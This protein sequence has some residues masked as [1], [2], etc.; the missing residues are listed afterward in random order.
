MQPDGRGPITEEHGLAEREPAERVA[1]S[2][3]DELMTCALGT[4][5]LNRP[6]LDGWAHRNR[7]LMEQHCDAVARGLLRRLHAF[8][9]MDRLVV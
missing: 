8:A 3:R 5:M 2:M 9:T 4:W 7:D 1:L 6:V